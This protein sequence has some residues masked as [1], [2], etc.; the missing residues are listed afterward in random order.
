METN[1]QAD[2]DSKS[3][4]LDYKTAD[5][6]ITTLEGRLDGDSLFSEDDRKVLANQIAIFGR[7]TAKIIWGILKPRHWYDEAIRQ[8]YWHGKNFDLSAYLESKAYREIDREMLECFCDD[9]E[10]RRRAY[11]RLLSS[12]ECIATK[13]CDSKMLRREVIRITDAATK[14][15]DIGKRPPIGSE[16]Q[17]VL[18]FLT[19]LRVSDG[20]K[21]LVRCRNF[22][23]DNAHYLALYVF[24]GLSGRWEELTQ[25]ESIENASKLFYSTLI[26]KYPCPAELGSLLRLERARANEVLLRTSHSPDFTS[27]VWFGTPFKFAK[28]Q[29]AESIKLLWEAWE[30]GEHSL[31]QATIGDRI[32]SESD[33][34]RLAHVFRDRKTGGYHPAWKTMIQPAGKGCF[35]LVEPQ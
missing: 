21:D 23:G 4:Q 27:V 16:I 28:G 25:G 17:T 20:E 2:E 1:S 11:T 10:S 13:S 9:W 19:D 32:C 34:F 31:S 5:E 14:L 15:S 35:R 18:K 8:A 33:K 22:K 30:V 7:E 6:I 24:M 3:K 12:I 26:H 29:Q